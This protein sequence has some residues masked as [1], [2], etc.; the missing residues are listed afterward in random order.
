MKPH[1]QQV[2]ERVEGFQRTPLS[3]QCYLASI[4]LRRGQSSTFHHHTVTRDTFY[5]V[6]GRLT[7]FIEVGDGASPEK[8]YHALCATPI[9]RQA[10]GQRHEVRLL[11]GEVLV[12][13]PQVVHCAANLNDELCE[14]LC[15]E[16]VG[17]YDFIPQHP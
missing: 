16:G 11:P 2:E 14:F 17:A 15:I 5:V 3:D 8:A 12:I 6:K 10:G 13:E 9:E 1:H 7:V 4:R